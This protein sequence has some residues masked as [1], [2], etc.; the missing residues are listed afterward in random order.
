M[1]SMG[2]PVAEQW[3]RP[4][5]GIGAAEVFFV[6]LSPHAVREVSASSLLSEPE[7]ARADRFLYPGPRRRYILLRA[8]ARS[9][10]CD[11]L[12]C[13]NADLTFESA[14]H[15][16][17]FAVVRGT[18]ADV[19]FNMSDSGNHGLIA[20]ATRARWHPTGRADGEPVTGGSAETVFGQEDAG[21]ICRGSRQ[22]RR[23]GF[24]RCGPNKEDCSRRSARAL[25]AVSGFSA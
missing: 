25:L 6:D 11:R 7:L 21:R 23:R 8:A 15:G 5:P 10:L 19:Q 18:P 17:P 9:L 3:W 12:S 13:G 24:Y 16:K 4:F 22:G 14:E 2:I 1:P 20:I